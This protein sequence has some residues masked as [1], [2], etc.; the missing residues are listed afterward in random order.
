M[1]LRLE[2][3]LFAGSLAPGGIRAFR[4]ASVLP[5]GTACGPPYFYCFLWVLESE[6]VPIRRVRWLQERCSAAPSSP[7]YMMRFRQ[8]PNQTH[9]KELYDA[10]T[11]NGMYTTRPVACWELLLSDT[12]LLRR[13]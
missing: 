12:K 3:V 9:H 5:M 13:P 8:C 1:S 11:A 10:C 7:G 6:K 2:L 4:P